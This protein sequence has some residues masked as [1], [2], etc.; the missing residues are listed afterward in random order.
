MRM[1]AFFVQPPVVFYTRPL[2]R[3]TVGTKADGT[4][5]P[6]D[7]RIHA[8]VGSPLVICGRW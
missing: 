3:K 8:G 6:L 5:I 2:R 7:L 4:P 1:P